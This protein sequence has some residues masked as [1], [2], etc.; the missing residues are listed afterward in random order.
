ML[1][2]KDDPRLPI[3]RKVSS[4]YEKGGAPVKFVSKVE[5][6]YRHFFYQTINMTNFY[7]IMY[8]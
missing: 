1:T 7:F 3:K 8:S 2:E 5:E 6:Y 4:F